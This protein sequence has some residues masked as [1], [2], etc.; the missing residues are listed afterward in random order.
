M[1][2]ALIVGAAIAARYWPRLRPPEPKA[3]I[4]A[5]T[6]EDAIGH[7][8]D[9]AA[10]E[11]FDI[12]VHTPSTTRFSRRAPMSRET[13][14]ACVAA[15]LLFGIGILLLIGYALYYWISK[16]V[17]WTSVQAQ[18]AAPHGA[19]LTLRGTDRRAQKDLRKWI[20]EMW[21]ASL[22]EMTEPEA[23]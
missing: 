21:G 10:M 7:V 22:A 11:G 6:P 23:V 14:I 3:L 15:I 1:I 12:T 20:A 16:P 5:E 19:T 4:V 13:L 8:V 9:Y 2:V 18:S 17:V